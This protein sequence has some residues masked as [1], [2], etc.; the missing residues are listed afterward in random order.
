[1][2]EVNKKNPL[3]FL[4]CP[5]CEGK[6]W[7]SDY[8]CPDCHGD[9]SG[10]SLGDNL[11]IWRYELNNS[12][13]ARRQLDRTFETIF[14]SCL[15]L[16]GV[17]GFLGFAWYFYQQFNGNAFSWQLIADIFLAKNSWLAFFWLSLFIDLYLFYR[18]NV[19]SDK[20]EK[21]KI[22]K[23]KDNE[24]VG[25]T[26]WPEAKILKHISI[27]ASRAYSQ[28]A[29]NA[30][31]EA[32]L[33]AKRFKHTQIEPIHF[34]AAILSSDKI[35]SL[36]VRLEVNW[37]DLEERI[38]RALTS[39]PAGKK[40]KLS[41]LSLESL[42]A[43]Y[44]HAYDNK[45]LTVEVTDLFWAIASLDELSAS[46]LYDL[47][48]D[49]DKL[50][51]VVFWSDFR[52]IL[53]AQYYRFRALAQYKPRGDMDRAM[54]AL[55]TPLLN[56]Y[57]QNL[58]AMAASGYFSPCFG[59][60]KEIES[61]FRDLEGSSS[62]NVIL[63]GG[64]GVGKTSV[65]NG[66]AQLMV[67]EDVAEVLQDKRLVS[68]NVP[69]LIGGASP[70][71]AQARF[72]E[73]LKEI[74][75]AGN[76]CLVIE[77]IREL[78]GITV[79][80]RESLDLSGILAKL[81]ADKS[82]VCLA[83]AT[84][85]DY[86]KYIERN[87]S[88]GSVFSKVPIV[89]MSPEE[90]IKVLE[91][92]SGAIEYHHH[93]FFSYGAIAR[94]VELSHRLI[95]EQFLPLKAIRVAEET[96]V[97][98][99]KRKGSKLVRSEDVAEIITRLTNVPVTEVTGKESEKLLNLESKI[100]ER[101]IGQDEAVK[102]AS[103]ALR[104]A[105][106]EM[107]SKKRPIANLLF[108][109]PTGVGK[110]ELTKTITEVYFGDEQKMIRVDMSEYQDQ[111]SIYRLIGEPNGDQGGFFTEAVRKSPFSLILLDEI[112][113]AHPDILN[114]FLQVLDDGRL[115][116][117]L[118]RVI[119]FTNTIIIATSNAGTEYIQNGI[120]EGKTLDNIKEGLISTQL[121]N[122][123]RPEFLNRFDGVIVFRPLNMN[124]V[125]QIARLMLNKTASAMEE[126]GV[127]LQIEDG[128][129]E[130]LAQAGFDPTLGARPLRRVIQDRVDDK[131]A[132]LFLGGQLARRD[133]VIFKSDGQVEVVKAKDF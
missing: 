81:L 65:I 113:K 5:R 22:K 58:T 13:I 34:I 112:E 37:S 133:T 15:F 1:M 30:V 84:E 121:R 103:S 3:K 91:V 6:G 129:L 109:G 63:V 26:S 20:R 25:L 49:L 125:K 17:A 116:D 74:I 120:K 62:G 73:V 128:C 99:S 19:L 45:K 8:L 44:Y 97:F 119:D 105:R 96:A 52:Q 10:I 39:R 114:L 35:K 33:L 131:L 104:R 111:S 78:I 31:D 106:A 16:L 80:G 115:T 38:G 7:S 12:A 18:F 41:L 100:H 130:T 28:P 67:T 101:I 64:P 110:T 36:L 4:A 53:S 108:L 68:L 69:M 88:L 87:S 32:Y 57:S 90:A 118:G 124:E 98:V 79:G 9:G 66:I 107:S 24:I 126:K 2:S 21:V 127:A 76:I 56:N 122:Y 85:E 11:L 132:N 86:I 47:D 43:A 94:S 89:E 123:F 117:G 42:L 93:V 50:T 83:T 59:R 46:I 72:I 48:V 102:M 27:N 70:E 71:E 23:S 54:T 51:N 77:N 75:A 14:N 55:A 92:H 29:L 60:D 40:L 61:I 95:H 82:F